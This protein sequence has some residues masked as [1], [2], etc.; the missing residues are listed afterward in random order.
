MKSGIFCLSLDTEL[1]W[2]RPDLPIWR[3]RAATVRPNIQ[4][5]LKLFTKY[6]FPATWAVVGQLFLPGDPL[7]HGPDIIKAIRKTPRQE[8]G[9]HTF[10]HLDFG[11]CPI[12]EADEDLKKWLQATQ[13]QEIKPG[14]F[15]FP[16]NHVGHLK[17]LAKHGFKAYRGPA[18]HW[19]AP[20]GK[21]GEIIDSLAQITPP[22]GKPKQANHGLFNF[23]ESQFYVSAWGLR[24]YIPLS[25]RVGKAKKGIRRAIAEK[26]LFHLWFHPINLSDQTGPLLAGLEEIIKFA[27]QQPGLEINNMEEMTRQLN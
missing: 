15:A 25:S 27:K 7:W 4:K 8:I 1:M 2:G 16:F 14:S 11:R 19:F 13:K 12:Q 22:A 6:N 9:C 5:L 20:L 3:Q 21:A 10:N 26:R 18:G 24:K 17:L 23:S